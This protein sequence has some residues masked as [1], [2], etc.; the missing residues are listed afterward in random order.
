MHIDLGIW[1][2]VSICMIAA[3]TVAVASFVVRCFGRQIGKP[4]FARQGSGLQC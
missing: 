4:R 2:K 3:E 1:R